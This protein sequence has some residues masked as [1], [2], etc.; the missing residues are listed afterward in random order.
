MGD[1]R[2]G[3]GYDHSQNAYGIMYKIPNNE[4]VLIFETGDLTL[5]GTDLQWMSGDVNNP[6]YREIIATP[7]GI[8]IDNSG[9]INSFGLPKIISSVGNHD[10]HQSGW[11][12][13]W[14]TYLPAQAGLTAYPPIGSD[15]GISAHPQGLYGSVKYGNAIFVWVDYYSM[16]SGQETFLASTLAR[17][18]SDPQVVWKFVSY[19]S[20]AVSC[21]GSHGD[22]NQGKIWHDKYFYPDGVDMIFAGDNHYYERT[23]PFKSGLV[24]SGSNEENVCDTNNMGNNIV[25]TNGVIHVVSGGEGQDFI[26][27]RVVLIWRRTKMEFKPHFLF[28]ILRQ[29]RLTEI[30]YMQLLMILIQGLVAA[31]Y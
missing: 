2:P 8:P 14:Q 10:T 16:P 15:L 7:L 11:Q 17:A 12:T 21:G 25:G 4:R 22:W 28:T 31:Q 29:S 9:W 6:G 1:T 18:K 13:R 23:C 19:H 26:P 3:T 5:D 20:P 27:F 30:H 24:T